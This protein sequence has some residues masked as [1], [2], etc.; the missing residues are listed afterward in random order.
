MTAHF[1]EAVPGTFWFRPA[2]EWL[3]DEL[4]RDRPSAW[5]EV[6]VYHGRSLAWLAVEIA[7]RNLPVTVHAVDSFAGWPGVLRHDALRRAFWAETGNRLRDL[8]GDR[9]VVHDAPSTVAAHSFA[10]R[11]LDVVWLDADHEY[12]AVAA[13]I[14]A[15]TPKLTREGWIGGDD[16]LMP[17]VQ[18][19]VEERFPGAP[20]IPG[21]RAEPAYTGAWPSWIARVGEET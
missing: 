18:Q 8:L 6:G 13:D 17:G 14:A 2:Y 1:Y 9:F 11:A 12:P 3:L 7:T 19:A 15:W 21:Y 5:C 20:L 10:D 4:P 16:Y